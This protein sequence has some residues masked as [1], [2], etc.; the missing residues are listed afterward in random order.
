M[1]IQLPVQK[2]LYCIPVYG[3][4]LKRDHL[5]GRSAFII[6]QKHPYLTRIHYS[7][8]LFVFFPINI[9]EILFIPH[10]LLATSNLYGTGS[11]RIHVDLILY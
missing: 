5:I 2:Y 7:V 4:Q 3:K 10:D 8:C 11:F 9:N 6:E 1:R